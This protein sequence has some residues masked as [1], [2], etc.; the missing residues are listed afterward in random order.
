MI[1]QTYWC[2]IRRQAGGMCINKKNKIHKSRP[3]LSNYL[4]MLF[5]F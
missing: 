3:F 5:I 2:T 1:K 4:L